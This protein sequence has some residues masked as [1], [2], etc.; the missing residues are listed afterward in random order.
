M[1]NELFKMAESCLEKRLNVPWVPREKL[2]LYR[3]R[4]LL[5]A[6][7]LHTWD[8]G[9]YFLQVR[10]LVCHLKNN[11]FIVGPSGG[12]VNASLLAYSLGIHDVDPIRHG[13]IFESYFAGPTPP[14]FQLQVC[15]DGFVEARNYL[16]Q[17]YGVQQIA[18]EGYAAHDPLVI[19]EI[20]SRE[21]SQTSNKL[22]GLSVENSNMEAKTLRGLRIQL[23]LTPLLGKISRTSRFLHDVMDDSTF[24]INF[25]EFR[26][27][28]DVVNNSEREGPPDW[29]PD[30]RVPVLECLEK[31]GPPESFDDFIFAYATALYFTDDLYEKENV[32]R[33]WLQ[34]R[35][36]PPWISSGNQDQASRNILASTNGVVLYK[37]QIAELVAHYL[38]LPIVEA[39]NWIANWHRHPVNSV[40]T[41]FLSRSKQAGHSED[42][43]YDLF[44]F[45]RKRAAKA[46]C[47][48]NHVVG[49]TLLANGAA[50]IYI[51]FGMSGN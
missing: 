8:I 12:E 17:R 26:G 11:G 37:E 20:P 3:E 46:P 34:V 19:N 16:I 30:E 5:E 21:A 29:V 28:P 44:A 38:K 6:D 15:N 33:E 2:P 18:W 10:K 25:E 22:F 45:L 43:A 23:S 40:A 1:T 27:A 50:Q 49:E 13:L 35:R 9:K 14:V 41:E 32:I 24:S 42:F 47:Y 4:L 36:S 7:C 48:K 31:L 51:F 39:I